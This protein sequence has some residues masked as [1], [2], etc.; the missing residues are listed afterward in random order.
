MNSSKKYLWLLGCMGIITVF[1]VVLVLSGYFYSSTAGAASQSVVF[2]REPN[3]GDRL[4]A[5]QPVQVRALARDDRKITRIELWVDGRLFD[6]QDSNTPGGINPFPLLTT[7]Y[8]QPGMHTLIARAFN[9]RGATSQATITVEALALAD[10]DADGVADEADA[11]P[12]QPGNATA[13]GCPDRDS[14]GI[15]DS[16]DACPDEAGM[17]EDGCPA[18]SAADR[19]GDGIIDDADACPDEAGSPL[20][21]GCRDADGDGVG[22]SSDACP[23]EAGSGMDGCTEAGGG[24]VEPEP[25][26]GGGEE[27][28]PLPGE[29]VPVPGE[30]EEPEPGPGGSD[31]GFGDDSLIP[32]EVEAYTFWLPEPY[33]RIWCYVRL[34]DIRR[35]DFET[36]GHDYW[37]IAAEL[38]GENSVRMLHVA[39]QPLTIAMECWGSNSGFEPVSLGD[40]SNE[41]PPEDWDGRQLQGS[42]IEVASYIVAYRICSPSCDETAVRAP[43]LAPV[44]TGP[45][46]QGPYTLRWRWD[47]DEAWLSHFALN[48]RIDGDYRGY[49]DL[50][51]GPGQR[52]VNIADYQPACGETAE[53]IV[54][55]VGVDGSISPWSNAVLW[56]GE[57]CTYTA[58]VGFTTLNVHNLPGDQGDSNQ[59]GPIYGE[60]W[61]SDGTTMETLSFNACSCTI[62]RC[63][64]LKLQSGSYRIYRDIFA[65]IDTQMASCLG[66][67]CASNDFY[68][69]S[70]GFVSVPFEDGSDLTVGG[71][72]MDC[73]SGINND[74]DVVFQEQ[75]SFTISTDELAYLTEPIEGT[76]VGEYA[77]LNF[78]IRL[79]R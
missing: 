35:Y 75:E 36:L 23:A 60:F 58:T 10:R 30:G 7:W 17:P 1:F 32:L 29:E 27:P 25:E 41:H 40:F 38:A 68:T 65:W 69:P 9:S 39:D 45:I 78:F 77:N 70:T 67:G 11:C 13:D 51:G 20:A 12:D 47:G 16:S 8:P 63:R 56:P 2:I 74:D 59:I 6:A 64:G 46:G 52:S 49:M 61:I 76:L 73:D 14:D 55:A 33:E 48:L 4:V 72:I 31:P 3:D 21:D 24:E 22:D 62:F 66:N 42:P 5:G 18:P 26:P 53:F 37:D 50:S 34:G 15:A 57:P 79:G 71:R 28:E 19:D 44:N 43:E 54:R